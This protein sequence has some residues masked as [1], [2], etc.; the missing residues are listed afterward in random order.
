MKLSV[1]QESIKAL[2][3]IPLITI[4]E[5]DL[6]RD[7]G[8]LESTVAK[9]GHM[10]AVLLLPVWLLAGLNLQTLAKSPFFRHLLHVA[11]LAGHF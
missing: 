1:L 2:I 8:E 7:D 5:L 10:T 11:T 4:S 9:V 3:L 6:D